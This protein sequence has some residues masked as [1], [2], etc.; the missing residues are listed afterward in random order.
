MLLLV[1]T[2][3]MLIHTAIFL[4]SLD[5]GNRYTGSK[6][7]GRKLITPK[8]FSPSM[9][10]DAWEP[11]IAA[12]VYMYLV[13]LAIVLRRVRELDF[14]SR[15][16]DKSLQL[17]QRIFRVFD[18]RVVAVLSQHL[19]M[20]PP[21]NEFVQHKARLG[22]HAPCEP[23]TLQ[24][25]E[26]DLKL[27]FEEMDRQ[28][29]ENNSGWNWNWFYYFLGATSPSTY[30]VQIS[31]LE[32][33]AKTI[34]QLPS[35]TQLRPDRSLLQNRTARK[36][37]ETLYLAPTPEENPDG[38]LTQ[39]GREQLLNGLARI[40]P[41]DLPYLGDPMLQEVPGSWEIEWLVP[42]LVGLSQ[43][44]NAFLGIDRSQKPWF[45]VNLRYFADWRNLV[46]F[47]F[48]GLIWKLSTWW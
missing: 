2:I 9:Y 23:M 5:T 28:A 47:G 42:L 4:S 15:S 24:S 19:H 36:A 32:A 12:N 41:L 20:L 34:A 26:G 10:H 48:L 39:R 18:A 6:P 38:T 44:I 33:Q 16:W 8:H 31:K 11:Y 40:N 43:G 30:E 45:S 1:V 21:S 25:M 3:L 14:S 29:A 35:H 46:F 7:R 22:E 37:S 13:P 17:L 27:L